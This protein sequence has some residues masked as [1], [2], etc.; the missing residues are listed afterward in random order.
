MRC[1]Y[2]YYLNI[3]IYNLWLQIYNIISVLP[4]SYFL[5]QFFLLSVLLCV[6]RI[7]NSPQLS[8]F[9]LL[10]ILIAPMTGLGKLILVAD[11]RYISMFLPPVWNLT[12]FCLD[13]SGFIRYTVHPPPSTQNIKKTKTGTRN[14]ITGGVA[15]YRLNYVTQVTNNWLTQTCAGGCSRKHIIDQWPV[16]FVYLSTHSRRLWRITKLFVFQSIISE[17]GQAGLGTKYQ[18]YFVC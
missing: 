17:R 15:L 11:G 2:S 5:K 1:H 13:L 14:L 8:L 9:F 4:P 12:P 3:V 7:N 10:I 6:G 18:D 16:Q